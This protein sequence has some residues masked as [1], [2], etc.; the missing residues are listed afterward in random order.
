VIC[1]AHD[2]VQMTKPPRSR[3]WPGKGEHVHPREFTV[4]IAQAATLTTRSGLAER[5]NVF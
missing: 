4:L 1:P 5:T 2:G 3:G